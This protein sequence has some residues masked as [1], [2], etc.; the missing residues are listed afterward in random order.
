M[1][2]R[3]KDFLDIIKEIRGTNF[4]DEGLPK[5]GFW[6]DVKTWH[7]EVED[8]KNEV[9]ADQSTVAADKAIVAADKATVAADKAIVAA[10][11]AITDGFKVASEAA[12]GVAIDNNGYS[13]EWANSAIPVSVAAGGNGVNTYSAKYLADQSI[14]ARDSAIAS[15]STAT[16]QALL[17]TSN[18][19]TQVG[20][21]TTQA[22]AAA[23][24]AS[25]SAASVITASGH[26]S[27]AQ[28]WATT[29]STN[30]A[31]QTSYAQ[32]WAIKPTDVFVSAA[33]GGNQT[34]DYS[35]RHFSVKS[36]ISAAAAA[37][38]ANSAAAHVVTTSAYVDLAEDHKI[39]AGNSRDSATASAL[40]ATTK[41]AESVTARDKAWGWSSAGEDVAVSDGVN[42]NGYSAYHWSRK[43]AA[44]VGGV[45][46]FTDLL[47][48]PST[49][50][51]HTG[52]YLRV[53]SGST[54]EFDTL[55]KNDVGLSNVDNTSDANK[56]ISTAVSTA[57]SGKASTASVNVVANDVIDLE[58][59]TTGISLLGAAGLHPIRHYFNNVGYSGY[60]QQ[61]NTLQDQ[62]VTTYDL[63]KKALAAETIGAY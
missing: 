36:G 20:L 21:A 47:D 56:P 8:D 10:D 26:S 25:A 23:A 30:G 51:G 16:A 41:A 60:V 50:A 54:I 38:S 43:A 14:S 27:T 53:S 44:I 63:V 55:D 1:P 32:E 40:T 15:A 57:L 52:K 48:T 6:F 33:A 18:G 22:N 58:T 3:A 19:A 46:N 12:R 11:K 37:V 17:A 5:E 13:K 7:G 4:T 42:P 59:L 28:G 61:L 2:S 62:A 45:T 49:Y 31:T 9:A 34:S 24:S 39:D 35:A 29:A